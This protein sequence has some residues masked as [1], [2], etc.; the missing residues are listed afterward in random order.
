MRVGFGYDAHA[1]VEGRKLVLGGVKISFEKGLL[2]HSDADVLCHAIGDALLGAACLGDLGS[3]FP[4][5]QP[6]FENISS[7]R[8]LKEVGSLLRGNRFQIH[9]IDATL[10]AEK[11][12]ISPYVS[13]MRAAIAKSL[14][15]PE[16]RISVK[17]TTSEGLGFVGSGAGMEAFAV[18]LVDEG[19]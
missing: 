3:H 15:I 17:A 10:V 7:L 1:L 9:N 2:G 19:S 4:D 18:A 5:D 16:A 8:L 11:P 6:R 13:Q 14:S 12:R